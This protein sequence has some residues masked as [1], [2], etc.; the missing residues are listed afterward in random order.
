MELL[1]EA[2]ELR[3]EGNR[4]LGLEQWEEA[5]GKYQEAYDMLSSRSGVMTEGTK[6]AMGTCRL[7][8]ALCRMK[9]GQ[10]DESR[11]ICEEVRREGLL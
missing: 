8:L 2:R 9:Q 3:L 4:L 10:Y 5:R 6:V 7:N 11:Q 1:R